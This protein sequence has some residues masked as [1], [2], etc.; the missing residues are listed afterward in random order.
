MKRG[1]KSS[2]ILSAHLIS[3][4][5]SMSEGLF[6]FSPSI[7]WWNSVVLSG[8]WNTHGATHLYGTAG[9]LQLTNDALHPVVV[10]HHHCYAVC[11]LGLKMTA[12]WRKL[13]FN[14]HKPINMTSSCIGKKKNHIMTT[15]TQ[16]Q[17]IIH[18]VF[19]SFT[20]LS[21]EISLS[22]N[23]CKTIANFED[24]NTPLSLRRLQALKYQKYAIP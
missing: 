11:Q 2:S 1:W 14:M 24:L 3:S 23:R 21:S 9:L 18:Y 10:A 6:S 20:I 16:Y 17:F 19:I 4:R 12:H 22:I 13:C 8:H 7:T 15:T 5:V